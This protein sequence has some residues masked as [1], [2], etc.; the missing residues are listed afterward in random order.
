MSVRLV[1]MPQVEIDSV[2]HGLP[3]GSVC[4]LPFF[5]SSDEFYWIRQ[6][7]LGMLAIRDIALRAALRKRLR[8]LNHPGGGRGSVLKSQVPCYRLPEFRLPV[9]P[10][11]LPCCGGF[12]PLPIPAALPVPYMARCRL[13]V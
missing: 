11:P 8:Y 4:R 9:C 1:D 5:P 12:V 7:H 10:K 6:L 2:G 13:S 3:S